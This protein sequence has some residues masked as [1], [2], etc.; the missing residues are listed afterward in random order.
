MP[1][2]SFIVIVP[3]N[4][5]VSNAVSKSIVSVG[6]AMLGIV[7]DR[8]IPVAFTV[9]P[10]TSIFKS[11]ILPPLYSY[12]GA[13]LAGFLTF[14]CVLPVVSIVNFKFTSSSIAFTSLTI[15][16]T[17]GDIS[18]LIIS[19]IEFTKASTCTVNVYFTS[20]SFLFFTGSTVT[21]LSSRAKLI[22]STTA[23]LIAGNISLID[24]SKPSLSKLPMLGNLSSLILIGFCDNPSILTNKP[25]V[26]FM[27]MST[28]FLLSPVFLLFATASR[29][30]SFTPFS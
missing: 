30:T 8:L 9:I 25:S 15:L 27:I 12:L 16:S 5:L 19:K 26:S 24:I 21:L 6:I 3:F 7:L 17:S 11:V 2:S 1:V 14:V 22:N 23:G 28:M 10:S 29:K 4:L 13:F 18:K 20:Y